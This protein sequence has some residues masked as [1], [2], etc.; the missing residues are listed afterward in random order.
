MKCDIQYENQAKKLL[1]ACDKNEESWK[2]FKADA[3]WHYLLNCATTGAKPGDGAPK[4]LGAYKLGRADARLA[5][6]QSLMSEPK[7]SL[8]SVFTQILGVSY[9]ADKPTTT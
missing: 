2:E 9:N 8:N 6:K 4:L 3:L 1:R 7:E 5:T